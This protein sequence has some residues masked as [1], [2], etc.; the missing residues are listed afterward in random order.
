M[1]RLQPV[2]DIGQRAA[3][4]DRHGV[5]EITTLHFIFDIDLLSQLIIHFA[6]FGKAPR[7]KF[8][9]RLAA[10]CLE[11]LLSLIIQRFY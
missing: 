2:T 3:D 1:D 5:V 6:I 9:Y 11:D 4:D 8:L 7:M 10:Y